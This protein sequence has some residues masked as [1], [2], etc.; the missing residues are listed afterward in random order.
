MLMH[1]HKLCVAGVQLFR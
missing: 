1:I